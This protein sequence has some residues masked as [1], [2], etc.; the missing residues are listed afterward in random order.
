MLYNIY[1]GGYNSLDEGEGKKMKKILIKSIKGY[2]KG[3]STLFPP[4]MEVFLIGKQNK[5]KYT[6]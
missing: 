1:G 2:Q 3:I 6:K 4:T 5:W